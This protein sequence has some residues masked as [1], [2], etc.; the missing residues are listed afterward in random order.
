M[1]DY[2][3][4]PASTVPLVPTVGQP[5]AL[6]SEHQRLVA[7]EQA[8]HEKDATSFGELIGAHA[9]TGKI[10]WIDRAWESRKFEVDPTFVGKP[11][12]EKMAEWRRLG[13]ADDQMPLAY[14][15][16]SA[17]H[18]DA[19]YPY[20]RQN[21][22]AQ[23]TVAQ[24]GFL[25]NLAAGATDPIEFA[26]GA[27]L[28]PL[29]VTS[30][31]TRLTNAL[32]AGLVNAGQG[33]ASEALSSS[34][35]PSIGGSDIA[36][37]G[38]LSFGLGGVLGFRQ[39][40]VGAMAK[41]ANDIARDRVNP[42]P[43]A[44][45]LGAA[46]VKGSFVDT[47]DGPDVLTKDWQQ[48]IVDDSATTGAAKETKWASA[49]ASLAAKLGANKSGAVSNESKKLLRD[50]L[51][52]KDKNVAVEE[53]ASEMSL[54]LRDTIETKFRRQLEPMWEEYKKANGMRFDY[55]KAEFMEQAG[56]A[57]RD[58]TF[59]ASAEAAGVRDAV[60]RATRSVWDELHAAGVEGFESP[61]P[62]HQNW[63]PR[64]HSAKGWIDVLQTKGLRFADVVNDL[65]APAIKAGRSAAGLPL[66]DDY[67]RIV[68]EAWARRGYDKATMA[69]T[70]VPHGGFHAR[71]VDTV[72]Q[73]LTEAGKSNKEAAALV[74]KLRT[75]E[76]EAS[77]HSHAKQRIVMDESFATDLSD[78]L[79]N[80]HRVSIADLLENNVDKLTSEYIR[81]MSGWA[82]LKKKA[83]VGTPKR[84]EEYKQFLN[85]ESVKS[86]SGDIARKLDIVT[87][88]ILGRSTE[89]Q[90]HAMLSRASRILRSQNYL[91]TM[92]QVGFSMIEGLGT[93]VGAAGFRNT[94]SAIPGSRAMLRRMQSGEL[95]LN[96]ARWLEDIIA[97]GTDYLRNQP[98]LRIDEGVSYGGH[99]A[100]A[101]DRTLNGLENT[102]AYAKRVA[103][104]ASF[105]TPVQTYL[106][107][108]AA[109]AVAAKTLQ[110]ANYAKLT[111]TQV[112][113]LRN[114]GLTEGMQEALF[115][116]LRGK[117]KIDDVAA[118]WNNWTPD[119][120]ASYSAYMWR[121][122][123]RAVTEG[124]VSDT[125]QI[126]HSSI[127]KIFW[128]FRS[129][130]TSSY[131][132]SLL[133]GLHMHDWQTA[134]M[135][136]G[137]TFFAG[138][139][140]AARN[141]VNT[142]GDPEMREK[143]LDP[144]E[145]GKQAFQ[146]AAYSSILPMMVDTVARDLHVR[147][148]L[149]GE[150]RG[151]FDHGRGTGLD[152]GVAGI[153]TLSTAQSLYALA[154]LPGKIAN[155]SV[156][157]KDVKDVFKLVWFQNMLGVRN[158]INEFAKQFPDTAN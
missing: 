13:I 106:Q 123:R 148:L 117:K 91:T 101:M 10:G 152:T 125:A 69:E 42:S 94:L 66:D 29:A 38:A 118:D 8:K 145:L 59:N 144:G 90:P 129:F 61:T 103:G 108:L 3:N 141:Y 32:R 37:A 41:A 5:T 68:A 146:Q 130:M 47:M 28:A 86:G 140:M 157:K 113:R 6:Q 133:N 150:D 98:Y 107:R 26:V 93:T 154:G 45:S 127:G 23:H 84:L 78:E 40:E 55:G 54:R 11:F 115:N 158:G 88:S 63:L 30:K 27:A 76:A 139:G 137:S 56:R 74:E 49:R 149:G 71:D 116:R 126:M 110:L 77:V 64:V 36:A 135:W 33:S 92:L 153:P 80:I 19:L 83:D 72:E 12:E 121:V 100:S 128:Q 1:A 151:F 136:V 52:Y 22:D 20:A 7:D 2:Q 65:I 43:T 60:N 109:R 17:A 155:G 70:A 50:G 134:K 67:G 105:M 114:D 102:M 111:K 58:P 51:G 21:T 99:T 122:T 14:K 57:M 119:E 62:P 81:E 142:V 46:R 156:T 143:L 18:M 34:Y 87:N 53:S 15:A 85:Q 96:E 75:Q 39:G 138:I 104:I 112:Y 35:N 82:A 147:Q 131:E 120:R 4:I 124:D 16:V 24:F 95:S 97:P 31:G 9:A 89:D 48:S 79:G 44:D 25:G 132:R 73:L